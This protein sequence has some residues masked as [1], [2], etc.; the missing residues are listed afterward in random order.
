MEHRNIEGLEFHEKNFAD[1]CN[2]SL[3]CTVNTI[4]W[5]RSDERWSEYA[6]RI[7][8]GSLH[9]SDNRPNIDDSPRAA[10]HHNGY[11]G[12]A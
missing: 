8:V 12:L 6:S 9:F 4:P 1:A 11:N 7:D 3:R 5:G 2:S 10:F